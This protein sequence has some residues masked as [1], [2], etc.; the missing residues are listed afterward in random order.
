MV[1]HAEDYKW[2][3]YRVI[4]GISDDKITH[5]NRTLGYF[6]KYPAIQYRQFVEDIGHKYYVEEDKIRRSVGEDELWLPC[7]SLRQPIEDKKVC[8]SRVSGT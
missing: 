7:D 1:Q 5:S 3:S 8:I 6:G 4:L 2:S